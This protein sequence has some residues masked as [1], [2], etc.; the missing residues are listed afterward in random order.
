MDSAGD[1]NSTGTLGAQFNFLLYVSVNPFDLKSKIKLKNKDS[2]LLST[3]K[4]NF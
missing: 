1:S 2:V 4:S 3:Y